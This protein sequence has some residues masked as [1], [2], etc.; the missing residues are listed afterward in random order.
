[1]ERKPVGL[2]DRIQASDAMTQF[3]SVALAQIQLP[4]NY[5]PIYQRAVALKKPGA[6]KSPLRQGRAARLLEISREIGESHVD[7]I[8]AVY[9]LDDDGLHRDDA[10]KILDELT[11][12]GKINKRTI[13]KSGRRRSLYKAVEQ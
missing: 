6:H 4:P 8:L 11:E 3:L 12:D 13:T 9:R 7:D 10:R 1:M 5:G 2:G